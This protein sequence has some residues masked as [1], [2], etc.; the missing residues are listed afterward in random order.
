[1][2]AKVLPEAHGKA[3]EELLVPWC[4]FNPAG[5]KMKL[6]LPVLILWISKHS[7]TLGLNTI[8]PAAR[9]SLLCCRGPFLEDKQHVCFFSRRKGEHGREVEQGK[10]KAP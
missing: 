10:E 2:V 5:E 1:M 6:Q 7:A 4:P 3:A 9:S 8:L